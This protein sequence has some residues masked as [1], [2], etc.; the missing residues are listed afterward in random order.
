LESGVIAAKRI[1]KKQETDEPSPTKE[2]RA[3]TE[4]GWKKRVAS[5][6]KP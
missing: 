1:G 2:G 6:E 5:S 4:K 3:A